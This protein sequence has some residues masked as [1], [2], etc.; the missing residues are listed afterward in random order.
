MTAKDWFCPPAFFRRTILHEPGVSLPRGSSSSRISG[1]W[2]HRL[3]SGDA[4]FP[5]PPQTGDPDDLAGL[6]QI[7]VFGDSGSQWFRLSKVCTGWDIARDITGSYLSSQFKHTGGAAVTIT[8]DAHM[9][10]AS[11]FG[12]A[13]TAPTAACRH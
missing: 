11:A 7:L 10:F 2:L 6:N 13:H 3:G 8:T 12:A 5:A 4:K 9:M 1:A